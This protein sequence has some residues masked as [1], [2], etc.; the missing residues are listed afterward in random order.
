ALGPCPAGSGPRLP[1][2]GQGQP[3]GV[4]GGDPDQLPRRR[5]A[6]AG[7]EVGRKKG[8]E[9]HTR[10]PWVVEG[11]EVD[12]LREATEFPGIGMILR[13]ESE[14]KESGAVTGLETRHF[15]T[16]LGA[17]E[18]SPRRLMDLV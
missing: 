12:Y 3:A 11:E 18:A 1:L 13:V 5:G 6:P 7:R 8:G 10:R 9:I 2:R 15:I 17:D 4:A 16:S 14:V